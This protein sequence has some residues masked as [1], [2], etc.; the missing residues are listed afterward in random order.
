MYVYIHLYGM[1]MYDECVD[2]SVCYTSKLHHKSYSPSLACTLGQME[3][4]NNGSCYN[5]TCSCPYGFNGTHCEIRESF[6]Y[7]LI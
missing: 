3:C 2:V 5:Q 6:K 7:V 1:C 4:M